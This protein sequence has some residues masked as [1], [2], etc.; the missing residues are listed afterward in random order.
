MQRISIVLF[1]ATGFTGKFVAKELAKAYKSENFTWAVAGRS[2]SKLSELLN[3]I[4]NE[5]GKFKS[6]QYQYLFLYL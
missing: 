4:K 2:K 6:N 5:L 1:G 3:E